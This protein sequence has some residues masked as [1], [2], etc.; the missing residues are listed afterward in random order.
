M[1]AGA[2]SLVPAGAVARSRDRDGDGIPNRF[3]RDVDG[4]GIPNRRDRDMDGDGILNFED[5]SSDGS[6]SVVGG[7]LP[8]NVRLP[9][10]FFGVVSD[11]VMAASGAARSAILAQI[12]QTGV[13][14]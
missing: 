10:S 7:A 5:D 2:S 13:G 4:D 8:A 3:D 9:R 6:G 12:A 1:F 11:D 14:T